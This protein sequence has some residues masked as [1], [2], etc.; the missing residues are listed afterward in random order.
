MTETLHDR[1]RHGADNIHSIGPDRASDLLKEASE[2]L[3][4]LAA[5]AY[6]GNNAATMYGRQLDEIAALVGFDEAGDGERDT[7]WKAASPVD[8]VRGFVTARREFLERAVCHPGPPL[9]EHEDYD[10]ET[11]LGEFEAAILERLDH[12]TEDQRDLWDIRKRCEEALGRTPDPAR[13]TMQVV[14]DLCAYEEARAATIDQAL[15][16]LK[17][18]QR[19]AVHDEPE[20]VDILFLD[21]G[22]YPPLGQTWTVY[23]PMVLDDQLDLASPLDTL[24]LPEPLRPAVAAGMA[25]L[26]ANSADRSPGP[27]P[28]TDEFQKL[29]DGLRNKPMTTAYEEAG[30]WA[31]AQGVAGT[32][33]STIR[34]LAGDPD[35]RED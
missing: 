16:M 12:E 9:S 10:P 19:L 23:G 35:A 28:K 7:S 8:L 30:E 32:G 27:H 4:R 11:P 21:P 3:A 17:P 34:L 25:T 14:R 18:G 20:R 6:I 1:L 13:K 29:I 22:Q 2:A 5:E 15:R 26:R 24:P 33:G 31:G